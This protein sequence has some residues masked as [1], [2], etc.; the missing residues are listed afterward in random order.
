MATEETTEHSAD[1]AEAPHDITLSGSLNGSAT[2]TKSGDGTLFLHNFG[3]GFSGSVSL[4]PFPGVSR[5]TSVEVADLLGKASPAG[6][7]PPNMPVPAGA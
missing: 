4:R 5:T 7:S 2:I 3:N 6:K 1:A